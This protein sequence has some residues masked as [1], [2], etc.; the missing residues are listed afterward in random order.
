MMGFESL[1]VGLRELL[2]PVAY[3]GHAAFTRVI[4]GATAERR[5]P[6]TKNDTRIEEIGIGDNPI[7]QARHGFVDHG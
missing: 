3:V 7:R 4:D 1:S 5:E 2:E 6:G